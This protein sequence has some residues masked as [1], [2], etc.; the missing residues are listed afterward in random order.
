MNNISGTVANVCVVASQVSGICIGLILIKEK[1]IGIGQFVALVQ[2]LSYVNEPVIK[3]IN[4]TV[5]FA[6]VTNVNRELYGVISK[7][8]ECYDI[9][10]DEIKAVRLKDISFRYEGK[11]DYV[12]T[13]FNFIFE[14]GK[15]Y[16]II[17]ESGSG[18]STLIKIIMG[19]ID[20][21]E[22]YVYFNDCIMSENQINH[23]IGL[24]SQN[25]FIFNDTIRNNVDLLHVHS[26]E[27][28][29]NAIIK[30]ELNNFVE[31]KQDR[32]NSQI[33]EEVIQVSGGERSRIA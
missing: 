26:D 25:I 2:L 28:V 24:V 7:C 5:A 10:T 3:L 21:Y 11:Q 6:S 19:V 13:R 27:E 12:I 18:K 33:S 4:S 31:S 14:M 1:I 23:F 16:L 8:K 22:G 17:G 9:Q 15:K 30:A 20:K 29:E 32:M